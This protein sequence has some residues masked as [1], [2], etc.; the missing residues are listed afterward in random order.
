MPT[1][2]YVRQHHNSIK[3]GLDIFCVLH[4]SPSRLFITISPKPSHRYHPSTTSHSHISA[5]LS[6]YLSSYSLL[7]RDMERN[8]NR[9][10]N[11]FRPTLAI[12][13]ITAGLGVS[14]YLSEVPLF[15][16]DVLR[17]IP[18]VSSMIFRGTTLNE[19]PLS[20]LAAI[21]VL[22]PSMSP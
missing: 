5:T 15:Q 1:I 6:S 11:R 12:W 2:Y 16:K 4:D 22:C 9:V 20:V 8:I 7:F 19:V 10:I 14:L 3:H 21:S 17:K 18:F 13:G